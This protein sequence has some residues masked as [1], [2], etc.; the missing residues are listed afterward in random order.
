[1]NDNLFEFECAQCGLLDTVNFKPDNPEAM[2]CSDC[3]RER[4]DRPRYDMAKASKAPRRKHNTRVAFP[5]ICSACGI[6][7][8]LDHIPKGVP[9]EQL[10]CGECLEK[11]L[12]PESKHHQIAAL[13]DEE[14][15]ITEFMV[16]CDTCGAD[17]EIPFRPKPDRVYQCQDCLYGNEKEDPKPEPEPEPE[18]EEYERREVADGVFVREKKVTST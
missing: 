16:V 2:L 6:E 7:E 11:E 14:A 4:G 15:G 13:K 9:I 1:M 3:H 10:K 12:P 18:P 17:T 5:I 8:T